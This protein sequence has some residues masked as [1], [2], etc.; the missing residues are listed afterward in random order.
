M[1]ETLVQDTPTILQSES[2]GEIEFALDSE[3][4]VTISNK[5]EPTRFVVSDLCGLKAIID[6]FHTRRYIQQVFHQNKSNRSEVKFLSQH[7]VLSQEDMKSWMD[8]VVER[9]PAPDG[10]EFLF[11]NY[12]SEFFIKTEHQ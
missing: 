8:D 11:C 2:L 5:Y 7:L 12:E 4:F 1:D 10:W 3:G 9:N 6:G